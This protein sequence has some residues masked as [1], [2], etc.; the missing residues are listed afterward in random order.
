FA[1]ES[2]FCVTPE[3]GTQVREFRDMVKALHRAGIGVILD[4]VFNHTS[5]GNH[6]GPA[7]HFK[8]MGNEIFYLLMPE[9]RRYYLNY[10]G[11]GNTFSC[12]HPAA[13]KFIVDCLEFWVREMHVDGFRFDEGSILTRGQD[14]LPMTYPPVVWAI[15]LSE[16][17]WPVQVIA[18]AWD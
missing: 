8:G 17:L 10:S 15:E 16:T 11:C 18:E 5:E 6:L 4:V 12:N 14:G 1:P 13:E 9:D 7:I 2:S 3:R